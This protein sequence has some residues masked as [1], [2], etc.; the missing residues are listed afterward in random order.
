MPRAVALFSGGLDSMLAVRVMQE[1]GWEVDALH[2]RTVFQCCKTPAAQAAAEVGARLTLVSVG[3]DYLD[4]IRRPVH[5]YGKGMNPCVDCRI[6]MA[7]M[8]RKWMEELGASLV[9]SGEI[10]GQREMSQKRLD[11]DRIAR[12]SGLEGRLLRPLCARLLAPTFAERDGLVDREK[13]YAFNG[14]GR[15]GLI[16][17]AHRL[18]IERTPTPSGGCPL[19]EKNFASR[20]RDLI[21]HWPAASRWEFELLALG[22]HFRLDRSAKAVLGR[23]AEENAALDWFATREDAP[24]RAILVPDSFSGP[25]ALLVAGRITEEGLALAG[26]LMLRYA[27]RAGEEQARVRLAGSDAGQVISIRPLDAAERLSPL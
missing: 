18:G 15:K 8:A 7:R 3:D 22:R 9:I 20:V 2:V 25:S 23:N 14:R 27:R 19:V 10:L 12:H 1:Q 26:A 5:G 11:L 16:E 4:L 21:E 24:E 17:L 13:L 6:Y